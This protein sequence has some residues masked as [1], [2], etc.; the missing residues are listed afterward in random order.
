LIGGE[1]IGHVYSTFENKKC[2][3]CG[4]DLTIENVKKIELSLGRASLFCPSCNCFLG[5]LEVPQP[6]KDVKKL[7][8]E[9]DKKIISK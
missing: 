1:M 9:K 3:N 8:K 6:K 5:I 7:S 4:F 2:Y